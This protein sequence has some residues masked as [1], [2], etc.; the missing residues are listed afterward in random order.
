MTAL[1]G[2]IN[3][4]WMF[5]PSLILWSSARLSGKFSSGG[6]TFPGIH[7]NLKIKAVLSFS[8]SIARRTDSRSWR[9]AI[10]LVPVLTWGL[11]PELGA[12]AEGRIPQACLSPD[13]CDWTVNSSVSKHAPPH[14]FLMKIAFFL[15]LIYPNYNNLLLLLPVPLHLPSRSDPVPFCLIIRKQTGF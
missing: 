13:P 11:L 7:E 5:F 4:I 1:W 6:T 12:V 14:F 9:H 3:T 2:P 10:S 15:A 8:L